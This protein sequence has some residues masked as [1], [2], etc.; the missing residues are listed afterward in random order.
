[1]QHM[2]ISESQDNFDVDPVTL[3]RGVSVA[4]IDDADEFG[5]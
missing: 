5:V 3:D 4:L 1:M 2:D